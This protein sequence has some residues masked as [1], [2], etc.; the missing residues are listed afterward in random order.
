MSILTSLTLPLAASTAFSSA[1]PSVLQGPHQVAQ[2]STITGCSRDSSMTSLAKP[3]S[4]PS[5]IQ[6]PDSVSPISAIVPPPKS[7]GLSCA[8]DGL[9]P[10][11][12]QRRP[13]SRLGERAEVDHQRLYAER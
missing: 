3:A 13:R 4:V 12:S 8:Q 9:Q 10:S 6:S 5:L 1:G 2:K 7:R 11:V